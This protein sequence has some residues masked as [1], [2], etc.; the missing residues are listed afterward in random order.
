MATVFDEDFEQIGRRRRRTRAFE[1]VDQSVKRIIDTILVALE[2]SGRKKKDLVCIGMGCPGPLDLD[3]G[4][5]LEAPNLNFT[6]V[7]IKQMLEDEFDCP[8]HILNDVDAGVYGEYRF[9]AGKKAR[10]VL[11]VFPGTG[12]GGGCVYDGKILRGRT[13]SCM[14]IGHTQ[15]IRGGPLCGCGLRGCLEAVASR[16]AVS[17]A[18][19]QFALRGQAPHLLNEEGTDLANIRSS[20]LARSIKAGDVAVEQCVLLSAEYV[21]I[22][23][24]NF[25]H[26]L[27]PD[28]V[29]LGGGLVE[30]I[31]DQ[32]AAAVFQ[33]A[34]ANVLPSSRDSFEVRVAKLGDD[35]VAKGASAWAQFVSCES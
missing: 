7:P 11:G 24:A 16:L 2:K 28:V 21:G 23:V 3:K 15:V 29:V 18:A 10:C 25:V 1:G 14:E 9:G 5:V 31:P 20:S 27:A 17:A 13:S 26:L 33:A 22:A 4:I 6:N 32:Y 19:V 30:A 8:V 35:S 34:Q 12:I